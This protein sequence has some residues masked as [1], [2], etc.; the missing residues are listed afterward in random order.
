VTLYAGF[1]KAFFAFGMSCGF[2]DARVNTILFRLTRK[3]G[4]PCAELCEIYNWTTASTAYLLYGISPKS[5]DKI[6][7][8]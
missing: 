2:Q 3:Y 6:G 7:K 5:D 1:T 4:L 8:Y